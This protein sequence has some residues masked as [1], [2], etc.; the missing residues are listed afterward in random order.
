MRRGNPMPL[1][2]TPGAGPTARSG[3]SPQTV[4]PPTGALIAQGLLLV[5]ALAGFLTAG[6]AADVV[7]AL[8]CV[9]GSVLLF[10]VVRMLDDRRRSS[11]GY[12]DWTFISARTVALW[13]MLVTAAI[14]LLHVFWA[15]L[16]VT[17]GL[18]T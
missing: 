2:E 18:T 17:R 9:F 14:G 10:G 5:F 6:F 11:I 7:I 8:L 13:V 16:E 4:R 1:I 15:A 12:A 3:P